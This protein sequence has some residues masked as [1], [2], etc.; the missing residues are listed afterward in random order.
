MLE[1]LSRQAQRCGHIHWSWVSDH[2]PKV[3]ADICLRLQIQLFEKV[4]RHR[5]VAYT[6]L[7]LILG[8]LTE[9]ALGVDCGH[10]GISEVW[11]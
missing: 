7:S 3:A 11:K 9:V 6:T 5:N 10:Y 2:T 8:I 4:W 1:S